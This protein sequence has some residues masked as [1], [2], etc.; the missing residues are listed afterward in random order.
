MKRALQALDKA[1]RVEDSELR[2]HALHSAYSNLTK[3]YVFREEL[4][5]AYEYVLKEVEV[6]GMLNDPIQHMLPL[7]HVA[8]VKGLMGKLEESIVMLKQIRRDLKLLKVRGLATQLGYALIVGLT[9]V[10][11]IE[12]VAQTGSEVLAEML[13]LGRMFFYCN[14]IPLVTYAFY[15]TGREEDANQLTE[16]ARLLCVEYKG[17]LCALDTVITYFKQGQDKA[18]EVLIRCSKELYPEAT[19]KERVRNMIESFEALKYVFNKRTDLSSSDINSLAV[20][21]AF[22][23]VPQVK[24]A[25]VK[26]NLDNV[27]AGYVCFINYVV[28]KFLEFLAIHDLLKYALF[29]LYIIA[30]QPCMHL[31]YLGIED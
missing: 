19:S 27:F 3:V 6:A 16:S 13:E 7:S 28:N 29:L 11:R 23:G 14:A 21:S 12:E 15:A 10:G 18:R 4:D 26:E 22:H 9:D 24:H 1:L 17:A 2:P 8:I 5:K 20:L 25:F 31:V 30:T